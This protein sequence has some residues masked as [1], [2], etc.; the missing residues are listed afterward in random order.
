MLEI[1]FVFAKETI[2][3]QKSGDTIRLFMTNH[4]HALI[5]KLDTI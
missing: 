2:N 3:H 4:A 1:C 5:Y